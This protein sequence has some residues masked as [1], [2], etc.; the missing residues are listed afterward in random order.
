MS[1]VYF[2]KIIIGTVTWVG[3]LKKDDKIES[4]HSSFF[5]KAPSFKARVA[6]RYL[7]NRLCIFRAAA[8]QLGNTS[9]RTITEVKQH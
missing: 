5:D 9:S 7:N 2:S 1:L 6:H 8:Y 4:R 3:Q